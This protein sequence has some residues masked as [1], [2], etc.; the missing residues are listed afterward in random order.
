MQDPK[1]A[2]HE[3]TVDGWAIECRINAEDPFRNFAPSSGILGAV[4]WPAEVDDPAQGE[5]RHPPTHTPPLVSI[6]QHGGKH[7]L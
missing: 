1:L 7:R 4:S 6:G 2:Q 5:L 3:P